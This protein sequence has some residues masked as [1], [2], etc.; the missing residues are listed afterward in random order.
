MSVL[1]A[2][3]KCTLRVP[4]TPDREGSGCSGTGVRH[5]WE[6]LCVCWEPNLAPLKEQLLFLTVEPFLQSQN[7]GGGDTVSPA[8]EERF[9]VY[10]HF[11]LSFILLSF[12]SNK[13]SHKH[14]RLHP[15]LLFSFQC[16]DSRVLSDQI[17]FRQKH[18]SQLSL[19]SDFPVINQ[20]SFVCLKR[21]LFNI[22]SLIYPRWT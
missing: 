8:P 5:G 18:I 7:S 2:S 20:L 17:F 4:G 10:S 13:I 12:I 1:P 22:C 21:S 19:S 9:C 15:S 11:N 6:P 3:C 14:V 16:L